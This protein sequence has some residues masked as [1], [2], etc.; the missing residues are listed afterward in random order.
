MRT[1]RLVLT[2]E[3]GGNRVP[4]AYRAL[5]EGA[6]AL[7]ATHAGYDIGA[8]KDRANSDE[9]EAKLDMNY[10]LARD[11][12]LQGTPA[13]VIGERI[14]RGYLPIEGMLEAVAAARDTSN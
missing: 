11:L 5:F 4:A 7:L 12:G 14:V 10:A 8:L 2:C 3:H 1:D 6:E 13:F 9:I